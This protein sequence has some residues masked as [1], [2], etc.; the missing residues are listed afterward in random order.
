MTDA[1]EATKLT[2][3]EVQAQ[4]DALLMEF[5]GDPNAIAFLTTLGFISQTFDD[6]VDGDQPVTAN[7]IY[8]L[9]IAIFDD[10]V[11]N[12]FYQAHFVDLKPM[13]VAAVN[14]WIQA[15]DAERSRDVLRLQRLRVSFVT[16]SS[17]TPIIKHVVYL[18]HGM[19]VARRAAFELDALIFDEPFEAYVQEHAQ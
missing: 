18:L 12:P 11:S 2:V 6:I 3:E 17:L 1:Q 5:V 7:R 9:M 10:L 14:Q 13:V 16:R 4:I 15:N 8:D 19:E